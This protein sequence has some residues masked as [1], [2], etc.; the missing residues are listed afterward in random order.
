MEKIIQS[1]YD[2]L[3]QNGYNK[4]QHYFI[5]LY[6][7]DMFEPTFIECFGTLQEVMHDCDTHIDGSYRLIPYDL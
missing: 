6:K 3:I 7:R 5:C 4:G 2:K 1:N